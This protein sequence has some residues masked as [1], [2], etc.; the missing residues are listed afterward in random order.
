M[1]GT[2][3]SPARRSTLQPR[4]RVLVRAAVVDLAGLAQPRARA[5]QHDAL[6]GGD[7]AQGGD[8]VA[9]HHAGVGVRQQP[10]LLQHQRAHGGQVGDGRLVPQRRQRLPRLAP[11]QLRLVAQGE[12][13]LGAAGRGARAGDRQHLLG[14]EVGRCARRAGVSAK[15]Q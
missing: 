1:K 4:L 12:Q 10:G 14:R 11:A 9:V 3:S 7:G 13:R 5:F 15:V 2:R 8:L 6:A